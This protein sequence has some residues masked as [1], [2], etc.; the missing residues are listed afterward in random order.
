MTGGGVME[1][2]GKESKKGLKEGIGGKEVSWGSHWEKANWCR[3]GSC[4]GGVRK[5][6]NIVRGYHP[7]LSKQRFCWGHL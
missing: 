1:S 2:R 3:D 6:V 4:S 5:G 7:M